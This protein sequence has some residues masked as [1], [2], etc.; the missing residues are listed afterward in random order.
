MKTRPIQ[1][2]GEGQGSR[3][4]AHAFTLAEMLVVIVIIAIMAAISLPRL[5]G[6]GEGNAMNAAVRQFKDDVSF[7]RQ[8]AISGRTTAVIVFISPD[9]LYDI[10]PND[11]SYDAQESAQIKRLQGGLNTQYA[12]FAFR[13]LGEQPGQ[14]SPRYISSWKTLPDKVFIPDEKF[15]T[16]TAD[17]IPPF[18]YARGIP[19]PFSRSTQQILTQKFPYIAFDY[20]GRLFNLDDS[21]QGTGTLRTQGNITIP[22]ARGSIL[23]TR[24]AQDV[25]TDFDVQEIPPG[26]STNIPNHIV[27]DWLTGRPK[28][29]RPELQ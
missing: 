3:R 6:L 29:E 25:V 24:N 9:V 23:Y 22:L 13:E 20:E 21:G 4:S 15:T 10:N 26:N 28:I 16:G 17:G 2:H 7:A 1:S 8:K 12:M 5:R 18:S 11:P 19:F 27:I 14:I